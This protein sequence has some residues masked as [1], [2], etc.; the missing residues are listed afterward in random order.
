MHKVRVRTDDVK[1]NIESGFYAAMN[2]LDKRCEFRYLPFTNLTIGDTH[3]YFVGERNQPFTE[4]IMGKDAKDDK[5]VAFY[6]YGD[7]IVGFVTVGFQN[8]HIYLWEA[9][10]RLMMPT[11]AMMRMH[12][13][14][15]KSIVAGVL[16]V[17][18]EIEAGRQHTINTPSVIRAEFTRE[19]EELDR[20]RQQIN[21]NIR[22]ENTK[23]QKKI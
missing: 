3:V 17:A 21:Q 4:I 7:E 16:K 19:I 10:K 9:M 20:F 6:V 8:L 1:Y 13:G 23:Q 2:M 5:F 15:F 22:S 14:D 11:A 12:D 18:P